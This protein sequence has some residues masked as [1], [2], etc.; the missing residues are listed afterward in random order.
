VIVSSSLPPL[1]T[2]SRLYLDVGDFSLADY[3]VRA[4]DHVLSAA[5]G[6]KPPDA[7]AAVH[8]GVDATPFPIALFVHIFLK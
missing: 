6:E 3:C 7:E 5:G 8:L 2:H 4:A 1:R